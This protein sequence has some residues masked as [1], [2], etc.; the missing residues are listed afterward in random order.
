MSREKLDQLLGTWVS[1]K[2]FVFIIATGLA[3]FGDLTSSDW[4]TIAVTYLSAQGVVDTVSKLATRRG[5]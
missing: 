3:L 2:L 5:Q 1:K 4:V